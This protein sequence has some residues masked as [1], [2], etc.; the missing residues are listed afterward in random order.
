[1]DPLASPRSSLAF[2]AAALATGHGLV[3]FPE[4]RRSP[5]GSL[6]PLRS[7]IGLLLAAHPVPV[8]PVWIEG[9]DEAMPIGQRWPRPARVTIRFGELVD[10]SVLATRGEGETAA[11]RITD[12]LARTLRALGACDNAGTP[13]RSSE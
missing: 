10:A 3:W 8:V 4:G 1:V 11:V 2:G 13:E 12:G 5:D 7:G 9:T 6:Q